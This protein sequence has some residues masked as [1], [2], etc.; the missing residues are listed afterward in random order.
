[1]P[2]RTASSPPNAAPQPRQRPAPDT[3]GGAAAAE[4]GDRRFV[5]ALAR[6]LQVLRCFKLG[7][8]RLGNQQLAERCQLPKSTVTRLTTRR[9]WR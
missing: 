4:R 2:A 9:T 3:A 1:M 7:E 6:G 8:E 5:S